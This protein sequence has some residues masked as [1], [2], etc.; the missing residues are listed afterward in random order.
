MR[1]IFLIVALLTLVGCGTLIPGP[2]YKAD[3][4]GY[5]FNNDGSKVFYLE[6]RYR[7]YPFIMRYRAGHRLY[8]YDRE[9]RRHEFIAGTDAFSVS[10][11][12]PL[13]LYSPD[14]RKRFKNRGNV[15][16]FYLLDYGRDEKKGY[17]MPDSFPDNYL[18]YGLVYVAWEKGGRLTAFVKF[19]YCPGVKPSSWVRQ[20]ARPPDWRLETWRIVIDPRRPGDRVSEA[21]VC[22]AGDI[23]A[24]AWR[25]IHR[26]KSVSPDG[27]S[28]LV[29]SKYT[30]HFLFNSSLAIRDDEREATEDIVRDSTLIGLAQ[31]GKYILYHIAAAP[32]FWLNSIYS[33]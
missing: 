23:P 14:W 32:V 29:F 9:R 20:R 13:L 17:F 3:V 8:L 30:G 25:D 33:W 24:V 31:A 18:S 19:V 11:Y 7:F 22:R 15:P 28:R 4:A 12:D 26:R 21:A 16:D 5:S 6:D 1:G 2:R 10:P 27:R